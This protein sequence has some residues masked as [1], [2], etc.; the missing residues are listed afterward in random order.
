[1]RLIVPISIVLIVLLSCKN[2]RIKQVK[3]QMLEKAIDS[4]FYCNQDS[5]TE[6]FLLRVNYKSA[7]KNCRLTLLDREFT[8]GEY[9]LIGVRRHLDYFF[10]KEE[11]NSKKI[12]IKEVKWE[13]KDSKDFIMVWY[14]K[15]G[16][17]W[18]PFDT[19]KFDKFTKF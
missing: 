6:S 18:L 14:K 17:Q 11:Y 3:K 5:I 2:K 12:I 16:E 7:I 13:T 4:T 1:M 9:G 19:F 8:L 10:T 15:Q